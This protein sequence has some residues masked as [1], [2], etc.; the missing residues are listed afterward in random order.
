MEH[1]GPARGRVTRR[2]RA[3]SRSA[4]PS[5][6]A[7]TVLRRAAE[8][9]S[10]LAGVRQKLHTAGKAGTAGTAGTAG[11]RKL[12]GGS[13]GP[14]TWVDSASAAL[15]ALG[16]LHAQRTKF[17]F[18]EILAFLNANWEAVCWPHARSRGWEDHG[19]LAALG[20]SAVFGSETD[21]NGS[22]SFWKLSLLKHDPA[23]PDSGSSVEQGLLGGGASGDPGAVT[24]VVDER[25]EEQTHG[26]TFFQRIRSMFAPAPA[27]AAGAV[28]MFADQACNGADIDMDSTSL[29]STDMIPETTG[30]H[31]DRTADEQT[32]LN[33]SEHLCASAT[34]AMDTFDLEE[35]T[36]MQSP[37]MSRVSAIRLSDGVAEPCGGSAGQTEYQVEPAAAQLLQETRQDCNGLEGAAVGTCGVD[38]SPS[39]GVVSLQKVIAG[40]IVSGGG[41]FLLLEQKDGTRPRWIDSAVAVWQ[42][43]ASL[44]PGQEFLT[45]SDLCAY[46]DANWDVLCWPHLRHSR[47][48]SMLRRVL[49]H[50]H[51]NK[52]IFKGAH[53]VGKE[54]SFHLLPDQDES[55]DLK[56]VRRSQS[57]PVE[58]SRTPAK[59]RVGSRMESRIR[60]NVERLESHGLDSA[61]MNADAMAKNESVNREEKTLK[62]EVEKFV[63]NCAE[64]L[65]GS[66]VENSV[67]NSVEDNMEKGL[68]GKN[69]ANIDIPAVPHAEIKGESKIERKVVK[70][71]RSM[72]AK[73]RSAKLAPTE[74][75][76][77]SSLSVCSTPNVSDIGE[78]GKRSSFRE[79]VDF[80]GDVELQS[81]TPKV[82]VPHQW[83]DKPVG[84]VRL[85]A[86]DR[87][88]GIGTP[89]GED[90]SFA[91]RG[92]KGFRSVRATHGVV[93]GDW[94]FQVRI[95]DFD[96]PGNVRVG[97]STRRAD[98]GAPVGFDKYGYAIRDKTG[99]LVHNAQLYSYGESFT[100][101][102]VIGCR[103]RLPSAIGNKVKNKIAE[104]STKWLEHQHCDMSIIPPPDCDAKLHRASIEFFKNG[105]SLGIPKQLA[106]RGECG[107]LRAGA[108]YPTVS[109]FKNG[110][111]RAE[112]G[113]FD[114]VALPK[115]CR[116][117]CLVGTMS[118]GNDVAEHAVHGGSCAN[119]PGNA[120]SAPT[121]EEPASLNPMHQPMNVST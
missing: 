45:L 107:P 117:F 68:E 106:H 21:E 72:P 110:C 17:D 62:G 89:V 41:E 93:E 4:T 120:V 91:V 12:Y 22:A 87:G 47:W 76:G 18:A 111:A 26:E 15:S 113:P 57:G 1:A 3:E 108:Y 119:V 38:G 56:Y 79:S 35:G 78:G 65:V 5:G 8:S 20:N 85:S 37:K 59:N 42:G 7:S 36:T 118:S 61:E 33:S 27:V 71:R 90:E 67:D 84:P 16:S 81:F 31:L 30:E 96:A 19:L 112:F 98:V 109:V 13:G 95:L 74:M 80:V 99:E 105:T 60:R 75:P 86:F 54:E 28:G 51:N 40:E 92:F 50:G 63:K 102:D 88:F 49:V 115:G 104:A 44:R 58:K 46:A 70:K 32:A 94:Y 52:K 82:P 103:L 53:S 101:G 9:P 73:R 25:E 77:S 116:P 121:I 39:T 6:L 43:L 10:Q 14:P 114:D 11:K 29:P 66:G 24:P 2:R 69:E 48:K 83:T 100:C 34:C 55:V 97:W 23:N 64:N